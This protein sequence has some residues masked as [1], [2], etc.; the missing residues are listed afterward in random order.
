MSMSNP[1]IEV[2]GGAA[3]GWLGAREEAQ[4]PVR[5]SGA[6][7]NAAS[8]VSGE[9]TFWKWDA[10]VWL[11]RARRIVIDLAIIIAAMTAVP[12]ALV[13]LSSGA[14][15]G[16]NVGLGMGNTR[17]SILAAEASRQFGVPKDPSIT[18]LEAG[19]SFAA[20]QPSRQ[21]KEFPLVDVQYTEAFWR[22]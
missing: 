13:T 8:P 7:R 2:K 3:A 4:L 22:H 12:V 18:P 20:L 1:R 6:G 19:R 21:S 17:A 10:R 11:R 15:W 9:T 16:S 14:D 5:A